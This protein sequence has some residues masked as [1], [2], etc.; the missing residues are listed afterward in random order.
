MSMETSK[1]LG[2]CNGDGDKRSIVAVVGNQRSKKAKSF[3]IGAMDGRWSQDKCSCVIVG[4]IISIKLDI[5]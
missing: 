1:T 4:D 5:I 2:F 3:G